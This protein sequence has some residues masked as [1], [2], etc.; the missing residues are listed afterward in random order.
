MDHHK[1]LVTD[2]LALG[3]WPLSLI[4]LLTTD[5]GA[6]YYLTFPGLLL[7]E[8]HFNL[9][10]SLSLSLSLTLKVD[11]IGVHV[12]ELIHPQDCS[13]VAAIFQTQGHDI[14]QSKKHQFPTHN[15]T[16]I[17]F[18]MCMYSNRHNTF[19]LPPLKLCQCLWH[20]TA[21]PCNSHY[22]FDKW[23]NQFKCSLIQWTPLH[24]NWCSHNLFAVAD[25]RLVW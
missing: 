7:G 13:E 4:R 14:E 16:N 2:L 20:Y 12:Q 1:M 15:I 19:C 22:H 11:V 21:E 3:R 17:Q 5:S 24:Q 8:P 25:Y 10:L 9:S 18:N 23:C 6:I